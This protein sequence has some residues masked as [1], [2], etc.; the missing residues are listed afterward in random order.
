MKEYSKEQ[1]AILKLASVEGIG[2]QHKKV[3]ASLTDSLADLLDHPTSYL[4]E[5]AKAGGD[6]CDK[7]IDLHESF[8]EDRFLRYLEK[9]EITILFEG[10]KEYPAEFSIL[11]DAPTVLFCRGDVT[12][13]DRER[14]AIVGCPTHICCRRK[15][16]QCLCFAGFFQVD[17]QPL[18]HSGFCI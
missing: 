17:Y 7:L 10:D 4:A 5:L 2:Y 11:D 14:F 3:I 13:L 18:R 8:D 1:I 15:S 16:T 6:V 9:M 12:L